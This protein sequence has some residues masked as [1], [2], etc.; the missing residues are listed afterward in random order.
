M[1]VSLPEIINIHCQQF[2]QLP[3]YD[4]YLDDCCMFVLS[5]IVFFGP[6]MRMPPI[7][8]NLF[9]FPS[10]FQYPL[11]DFCPRVSSFGSLVSLLTQI[12]IIKENGKSRLCPVG[13]VVCRVSEMHFFD[14]DS[15]QTRHV[16]VV[17]FHDQ[18]GSGH[19]LGQVTF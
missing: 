4:S 13:F 11:L 3:W 15:R 2:E 9:V 1:L 18:A 17:P 12:G 14:L 19:H 7:D 8:T 10:H 5:V 6:S 16:L